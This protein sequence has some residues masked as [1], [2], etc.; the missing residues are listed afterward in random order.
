MLALVV[1]AVGGF[2]VLERRCLGQVAF[3]QP[4]VVCALGG[5]A[6]GQLEAG[7]WLGLSLQLLALVPGQTADFALASVVTGLSLALLSRFAPGNLTAGQPAALALA[8]V[9]L[10]CGIVGRWV[11]SRWSIRDGA[12]LRQRSLW[13]A[14]RPERAL[15]REVWWV[16]LRAF[17]VG[18]VAATGGVATAIFLVVMLLPVGADAS[19][20]VVSARQLLLPLIGAAAAVGVLA[21]RRHLAVFAGGFALCWWLL[22]GGA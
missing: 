8:A 19:G 15:G 1:F 11:E 14:D 2:A 21:E 10:L 12:R 22:G 17:L 4:L 9:A 7:I 18:G 6:G 13:D 20:L 3:A 5:A 16:A